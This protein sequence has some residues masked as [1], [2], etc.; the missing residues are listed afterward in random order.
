ML[1]WVKVLPAI[2]R[3]VPVSL[4]PVCPP[5]IP[6]ESGPDSRKISQSATPFWGMFGGLLFGF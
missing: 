2:L 3:N 6:E 4:T 1:V 5:H